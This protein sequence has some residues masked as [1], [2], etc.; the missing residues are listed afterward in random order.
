MI[1]FES[2]S[3]NKYKKEKTMEGNRQIL[4]FGKIREKLCSVS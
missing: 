1:N 2:F 3:Q 4:S